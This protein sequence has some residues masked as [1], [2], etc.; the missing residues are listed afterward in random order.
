MS[1]GYTLTPKRFNHT[2][3]F[4]SEELDNLSVRR[5]PFRPIDDERLNRAM[6]ASNRRPSC[7]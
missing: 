6:V 4:W 3:H 7:C 2:L 1:F 5:R